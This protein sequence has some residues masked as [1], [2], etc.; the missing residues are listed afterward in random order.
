MSLH[1]IAFGVRVKRGL[2]LKPSN[3][4]WG[5]QEDGWP[6]ASQGPMDTRHHSRYLGHIMNQVD[7]PAL[8][9]ISTVGH[10]FC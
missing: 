3:I 8:E 4:V 6:R 7:N 1:K 2:S 5:V 10:I 9:I